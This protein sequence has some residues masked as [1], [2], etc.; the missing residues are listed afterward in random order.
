MPKKKKEKKKE[1]IPSKYQESILDFVK[2]GHGNCV[3]EASA[4]AAKT[5]TAIMC[6]E[7]MGKDDKILLTA[8]NT[9]IVDELKRKIKGLANKDNIDCRTMHSL[10]YM[11]LMA[12][13]PK[14]I[15]PKPNDFK[16]S[17]Y[18]YNNIDELSDGYYSTLNS[19]DSSKYIDNIKRFVDFGRFYLCESANDLLFVEKH[20]KIP[21]YYNE[22]EVALKV[23]SWGKENYQ[24]IDFTDMVWLPNVLNCKPYGRLYDW[25]I[26]DECQDTMTAERM[27]LLRCT[28]MSTRMLF[29]GEKIQCQPEGTMIL[30]SDGTEKDIKDIKV[31]DEVVSYHIKKSTYSGY[32]TKHPDHK[33]VVKKIESHIDKR[34]I[35]IT[36]ENGMSSTY[37]PEHICLAKFNFGKHSKAWGIAL[38]END[39]GMFFVGRAL[40][41]SNKIHHGLLKTLRSEHCTRG[42]V[43]KVLFDETEAQLEQM[44]IS[45]IY[46][47]PLAPSEMFGVNKEEM[48]RNNLCTLYEAIGHNKIMENALKCL[49]DFKKIPQFPISDAYNEI[50]HARTC[51]HTIRACNL[52]PELMEVS[53]FDLKQKSKKVKDSYRYTASRIKS[54]EYLDEEKMVY[55]LDVGKNHTYV[56]D[57][58]AT[59]NCIYSFMGSDYRS[60]DELRKLPNTISLPLSISYRCSQ[61]VVKYAKRFNNRIES[62]DGAP[63]G[64]VKFDAQLEDIQDGD[65]VLCRV[66]APLLQLYCELAKMG[67]P[68]YIRGKDVGANLIKVVEKTKEKKLNKK[69]LSK[70]VFSKLYDKLF[71]EIDTVMRKHHITFEMAMDDSDVSQ[72]YD[73]IQ[74]L[75]AISEDLTTSEELVEK[76]KTLFS[77]KK[78]KGISLSTIHKAKGLEADNVF[79]CCPSLLPAKSAKEVWELQQESNLEYV[80]YTRAKNNLYFLDEG[81]FSTYSSNSQ[82][83][84]TEL[85]RIK[86]QIFSLYGGNDRCKLDKPSHEAARKIIENKTEIKEEKGKSIDLNNRKTE[87]P[88][89]Q[90]VLPRRK[91]KK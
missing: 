30:M 63:E 33:Y 28:K 40:L 88:S 85:E 53:Y 35:K 17:G 66:N 54:I 81:K 14:Q 59:H 8:F 43:L 23:M 21:T 13:Y 67:K 36:T 15:E 5:T 74:A 16:Y 84:A 75:G 76:I 31:G 3:V 11:L 77:D 32:R 91:K 80:A 55:S 90:F 46:N 34:F 65:M 87:K 19:K 45:Q 83:K 79:I 58:I 49:E 22:K 20:Y 7:V 1:L 64:M 47:I 4:G 41:Y 61:N 69:T 57:G 73:T 18:I 38:M 9:D 24:T 48:I 27:L 29:F 82:Q 86:P 44:R 26:C 68:A 37:T 78:K 60:F 2:N 89:S 51:L 39:M 70:G 52:I 12:N 6:L 42:W 50:P 56:A 72:M 10:G 62:R 71:D 25:I